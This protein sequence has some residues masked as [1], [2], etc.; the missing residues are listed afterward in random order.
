MIVTYTFDAPLL[1]ATALINGDTSGLSDED[2]EEFEAWCADHSLEAAEVVDVLGE[3]FNGQ[4]NGL[5]TEMVEYSAI[6][7]D[8]KE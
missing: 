4:W 5:L 2:H 8:C 3:P 6:H 7:H 1:W